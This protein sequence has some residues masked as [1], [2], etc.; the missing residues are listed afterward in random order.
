MPWR[1][2]QTLESFQMCLRKPLDFS[3]NI[4]LSNKMKN[5]ISKMLIF[6]DEKGS[7]GVWLNGFELMEN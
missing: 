3:K 1:T 7:N 4:E 5:V 2:D 6:K